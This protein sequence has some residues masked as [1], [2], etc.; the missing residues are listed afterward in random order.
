MKVKD[1]YNFMKT[2]APEEMAM[3]TDNVGLLVG[4]TEADV[5]KVLI[6][7]DITS[8]V[9]SEAIDSGAELIVAH[10]PLFFSLKTVT[11]TDITGKKIVQ[12]L[13]NGVSCICMHTNL[14]AV[15][16]G[17]NDALAIAVGI[18]DKTGK[19]D[20]LSDSV[21]L[22]S[23]DVVS[24]GRVGFLSKEYTMPEFLASVQKALGANGLR[25]YDAGRNVYKVAIASGSGGAEWENAIK[26][27][28]DTFVT[29]DIKYHMF[30]DAKELG[31]NL[32]DGGHY[33]TEN[34]ISCVLAEKLC[35]AFPETKIIISKALDQT[36][37]FYKQGELK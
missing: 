11:D 36:I 30:L 10:H 12:M 14:D 34:V 16:D 8:D 22:G 31:I 17:V 32:V 4:K 29:A 28:C 15:S 2:I 3:E 13:S 18:A 5:S 26:S 25:Y 20:P 23:G 21:R 27:G 1:I 9:I 6:A 37:K 7:L 35:A 24:L 33:C 19:A